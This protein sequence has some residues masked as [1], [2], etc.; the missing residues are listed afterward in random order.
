MGSFSIWHWMIV[1]IAGAVLFGGK[2][3]MSGVMTD[4]A[5]GLKAFKKTMSEN[6]DDA[7]MAA[8]AEH[9]PAGTIAGPGLNAANTTASHETAPHQG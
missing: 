9:R 8:G 2:G 5:H 3:R 4:F 6:S 7:S 1:L